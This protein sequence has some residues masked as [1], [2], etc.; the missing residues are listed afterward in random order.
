MKEAFY[1]GIDVSKGYADIILVNQ[2][3]QVQE[4]TFQ[5]DDNA[6]GHEQLG[7]VIG[8]YTDLH[9][10]AGFYCGVESTGGYERNWYN[11]L[12]ALSKNKPVKVALL[13]PVVVKGISKASLDRTVTDDVS[14]MNI[15]RYLASYHEK[16]D[17]RQGGQLQDPF[18]GGRSVYSYQKMLNKQ[19]TQL[20]N[21]LE[22]LL[23]QHFPE[24]LAYCRNGMPK[25]VLRTLARY[26]TPEKI[27]KAGEG[28]LRKIKGIGPEKVRKI[29]NKASGNQQ[30]HPDEI[31]FVIKETAREILHKEEKISRNKSFLVSAYQGHP[32]VQLLCTIPGI[33]LNSAIAILF[34]IGH[35]Q[36]FKSVK[37]LAA[38][39]GVNPEYKQSGDGQWK[40]HMS[41]KGRKLMRAVLF[42]A[43]FTNLRHDAT[44]KKKYAGILAKGKNHYF[45]MGVLMH[46]MLRTIYG[47]LKSG[48][49]YDPEI[50]RKNREKA[51]EKQAGLKQAEMRQT[52]ANLKTKRRYQNLDLDESPVSKRKAK[53]IK[54]LE[55]SQEKF[56][57]Q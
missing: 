51:L 22:K 56:Y 18:E 53:K 32:S 57:S 14:A 41:K 50:D 28:K 30:M 24:V 20:G 52:R 55:T 44:M 19:K 23:Y 17:Y 1:L 43:C 40:T 7:H 46:K 9:P 13:N 31:G 35:I 3:Q 34:E 36:R 37:G 33:G 15:A 4:P 25:W 16:V 38:Y 6:R 26:P 42:M 54:E 39:F 10:G 2:E 48:K 27:K 8:Q 5:L 21:Q 47:V 45:A 12:L 11:Y 49:A 29:V